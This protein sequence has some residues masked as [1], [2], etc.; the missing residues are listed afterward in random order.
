MEKDVSHMMPHAMI[1]LVAL[2]AIVALSAMVFFLK[3]SVPSWAPAWAAGTAEP[4][5]QTNNNNLKEMGS[6]CTSDSQC[7]SGDCSIVYYGP[8]GKE[9]PGVKVC[10]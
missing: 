5:G 10:G 6:F 9:V 2:V 1:A 4:P 3:T 8:S 7:L